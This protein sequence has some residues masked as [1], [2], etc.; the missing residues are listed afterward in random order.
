MLTQIVA[1]AERQGA[2]GWV[3]SHVEDVLQ[4]LQSMRFIDFSPEAMRKP[5]LPGQVILTDRGEN[6]SSVLQSICGDEDLKKALSGWVQELTPMDVVDFDFVPDAQGRILVHLIEEGGKRTSA[7]SAS[8]GTLRFLGILA[9]LLGP[10]PARFYFLEEIDNGIHP[11][12][13]ALLMDLLEKRSRKGEVQVVAS[14]HSPQV[15]R[16]IQE[17]DLQYVTLAYRL[18]GTPEGR[19]KALP[20]I[21]DLMEVVK[22]K[23]IARLHESSWMENAMEFAEGTPKPF[24]IEE[25]ANV[26]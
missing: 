26:S 5:S 12:R 21:P 3:K 11:T 19:L 13:L 14:T 20:E 25:E 9:A 17:T 24:P 7:N 6:L 2:T 8:D 16:L 4:G 1:L 10:K 15:L 22:R 23:D 18:K